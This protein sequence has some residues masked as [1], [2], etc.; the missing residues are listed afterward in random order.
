MQTCFFF[1]LLRK[2]ICLVVHCH[3]RQCLGL[4]ELNSTHD[5]AGSQCRTTHTKWAKNQHEDVWVITKSRIDWWCP[6]KYARRLSSKL[7]LLDP[8]GFWNISQ[9]RS[10]PIMIDWC[11]FYYFVG[12]SLIALLESE[13]ANLFFWTQEIGFSFCATIVQQWKCRVVTKN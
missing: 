8:Q 2:I 6:I 13:C 1:A 3:S 7:Y 10:E 11:C 9:L 4:P 5:S 12:N